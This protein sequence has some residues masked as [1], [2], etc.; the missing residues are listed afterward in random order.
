MEENVSSHAQDVETI[1]AEVT[2]AFA[3]EGDKNKGMVWRFK[4]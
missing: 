3:W 4:D 1:A 2:V